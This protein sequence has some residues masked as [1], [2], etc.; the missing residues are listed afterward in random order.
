[1]DELN[2]RI[3]GK[4]L[5]DL[6]NVGAKHALYR[7]DGKWHHILTDFP[8]A[9]FNEH[10][11]IRF[12]SEEEFLSCEYLQIQQYVLVEPDGIRNIPG[13]IKVIR[14]DEVYIPEEVVEQRIISEG[15]TRTI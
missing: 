14:N 4:L 6:W 5:N 2:V 13:Y 8:G 12:E 7:K 9:L 15:K 3:S 1:M 10:G 11:Y